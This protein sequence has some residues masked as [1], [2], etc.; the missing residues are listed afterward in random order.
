[1][2]LKMNPQP[3]RCVAFQGVFLLAVITF[4]C[5]YIFFRELSNA[6][7]IEK[8]HCNVSSAGLIQRKTL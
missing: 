1:M 3:T 8:W 6:C 4:C 5:V 2:I 7:V